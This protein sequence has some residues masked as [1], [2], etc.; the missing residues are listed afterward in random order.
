MFKATPFVERVYSREN[1]PNETQSE[2]MAPEATF[3]ILLL[4]TLASS[5]GGKSKYLKQTSKSHYSI[6][7]SCST[8][9]I[10]R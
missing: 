9:F 6:I 4:T 8:R 2:K 5:N 7:N 3:V 10:G 1:P